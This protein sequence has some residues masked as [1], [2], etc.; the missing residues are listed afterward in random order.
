MKKL[1][2]HAHIEIARSE[3]NVLNYT[4]KTD[5]R[6]GNVVELGEKPYRRNS[7]QDWDE[8]WQMAKTGN[9]EGIPAEIRI[10]HYRTLKDIAKDNLVM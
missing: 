6:I 3:D 1:D 4:Q 10:K 8:I 7:K 2:A 9:M 5:T